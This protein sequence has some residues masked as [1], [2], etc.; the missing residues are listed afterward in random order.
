LEE[1]QE[2]AEEIAR[3]LGSNK[4]WHSH[5]RMIGPAAL[6]S[7]LRLQINDYSNDIS[8]RTL[9]RSYNDLLTEYIARQGFKLFLHSR[10]YF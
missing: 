6:S 7:V 10:E 9:V 2:R 8:L 3:L 4:Q 5:A 1:K